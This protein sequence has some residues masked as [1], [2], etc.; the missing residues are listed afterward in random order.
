MGAE[1]A[2]FNTKP[3]GKEEKPEKMKTRENFINAEQEIHSFAEG[4]PV[5]MWTFPVEVNLPD[6]CPSSVMVGGVNGES[7]KISY[8]LRAEI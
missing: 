1:S 4:L 2:S 7:L 5:G 6:W 8:K 3:I